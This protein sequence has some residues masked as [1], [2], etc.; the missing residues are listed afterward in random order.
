MVT[1]TSNLESKLL[2]RNKEETAHREWFSLFNNLP[3]MIWALPLL[4]FLAI[5][6]LSLFMRAPWKQL[7]PIL[8]EN[9]VF[10][11]IQLSLLSSTLTTAIALL[12]GTPVAVFLSKS[13][14][15]FRHFVDTLIDLPTVL[16]P[17]VAGVALLMAFGQKGVFGELLS[18]AGIS[19]PFTL[20]AVILAQTFI[21]SPLYVKTATVGF[22]GIDPILVQAAELDGANRWQIFRYIVMP[23]SWSSL[24]SGGVMTWARSLGEFGATIIF[25]GN[26]PGKT[27]TM[28]LAIYIGFEIDMNVAITLAIIMI[29][30][31]FLT[32]VLV[33]GILHRHLEIAY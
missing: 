11:A 12:V 31:S 25:A 28:P 17:S 30:I 29:C 9:Q 19:I 4:L 20:M 32:L 7:M 10:Q 3:W 1:D 8:K 15:R 14:T 23:L 6:I 13:K 5:P 22:S 21:A 16:P 24:L 18:N 33:K 27:Q 2:K 26:F